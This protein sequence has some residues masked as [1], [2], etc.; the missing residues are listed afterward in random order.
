M[1]SDV[2][3]A[4]VVPA[5]NWLQCH[6]KLER[7]LNESKAVSAISE[8]LSKL[9]KYKFAE[10]P[11]NITVKRTGELLSCSI[12][13]TNLCLIFHMNAASDDQPILISVQSILHSVKITFLTIDEVIS[14]LLEN[15]DYYYQSNI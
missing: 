1:Q 8:F 10:V 12:Y 4:K 5:N 3:P 14:H 9:E 6:T 15:E 11:Y 13:W 7:L 2:V